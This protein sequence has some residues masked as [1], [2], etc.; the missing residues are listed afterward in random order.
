MIITDKRMQDVNDIKFI[1]NPL[2]AHLSR[3]SFNDD[4]ELTSRYD[5]HKLLVGIFRHKPII[6]LLLLLCMAISWFFVY[7]LI[8]T[9]EADAIVLYQEEKS[10]ALAGGNTVATMSLPT[11]LDLIQ[12][13][14][15]L[16]MVKK[17]LGIEGSPKSLRSMIEIPAPHNNSNFIHIIARADNQYLAIDIANTLAKAA[18]KASQDF[19]Q[20]QLLGVLEGYKTQLSTMQKRLDSQLKEIEEFKSQNKSIEMTADLVQFTALITNVRSRLE[21]ASL[22]YS[23]QLVEYEHL[24]GIAAALPDMVPIPSN[25]HK[26]VLSL[27]ANISEAKLKYAK[28][29][30]RLK[31]LEA[32]LEEMLKDGKEPEAF[33]VENKAKLQLKMELQRLEG[34]LKS[35]KQVKEDL[36]LSYALLNKELDSLPAKQTSF[37]KLL[38]AKQLTEDGIKFLTDAADMTQLMIN[39]PR[40]SLELY[41][42]ADRAQQRGSTAIAIALPLIA[43]LFGAFMGIAIAFALEMRDDKIRTAQQVKL[44]YDL[45]CLAVIPEIHNVT[46]DNAEEKML[47][48]IRNIVARL[49]K[50]HAGEEEKPC[51]TIGVSSSVKGEGKNLLSSLLAHY[52]QG[53]GKSVMLIEADP[54][55]TLFFQAALPG[56]TLEDF[57]KNP[58]HESPPIITG[59]IH[60][61]KVGAQ[62]DETLKE[63]LQSD[64]MNTFWKQLVNVYQVIIIDIPSI[65]DHN[66]SVNFLE[67]TDNKL[68][69]INSSGTPEKIVE[70]SLRHINQ[71]HLKIDGII[72]NRVL[73]LFIKDQRTLNEM[74]RLKRVFK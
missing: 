13:P 3:E 60:Q 36:E 4:E 32:Q 45:P 8:T 15:N 7:S 22:Q 47:F 35:I 40:G 43:G 27:E 21:E 1:D 14:A 41:E 56:N 25:R 46:A 65:I 61:I 44:K 34:R 69:V 33:M 18:V 11:V 64:A 24:N 39:S 67:L 71:H 2:Q 48:F 6:L 37:S 23:G 72:L 62:S 53:L 17:I 49:E 9:Y 66:Y 51:L 52:Y 42:L 16:A 26:Q 55:A 68:F 58:S 50:L 57:L 5:I 38:N 20:K 30:P 73:P 63:L 29:N 70:E 19:T 12:S 54:H 59:K 74:Q 10:I 28:D 31:A